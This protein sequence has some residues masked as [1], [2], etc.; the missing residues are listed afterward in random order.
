MVWKFFFTRL[1]KGARLFDLTYKE[2]QRMH[3]LLEKH[4]ID[5]K[6]T[7]TQRV[8]IHDNSNIKFTHN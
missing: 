5:C 4:G 2:H 1:N 7:T 3:D 8:G 6:L